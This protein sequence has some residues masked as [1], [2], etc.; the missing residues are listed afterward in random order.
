MNMDMNKAFFLPTEARNPQW[1]IIDAKEE[2]LVLGRMATQIAEIL[3]GK[4]KPYYT[5]HTDAGD[6]VIVINS[7]Y[8]TMSGNKMEDKI[9]QS[10]SG[11]RG[12]RKEVTAQDLKAKHPEALLELAVK[13]MLPKNNLNRGVF[14]KLHIYPGAEH[15]HAAQKP[16]P[17]K[18]KK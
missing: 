18:L 13:R 7:D 5:P 2:N 16:Q 9:Y 12:N 4:N 14:A 3:R 6:H 1:L 11:W 10:Y 8:I 17:I 15:P